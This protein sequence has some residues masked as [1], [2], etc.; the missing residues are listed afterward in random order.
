MKRMNKQGLIEKLA[1]KLEVTKKDAEK[2]IDGVFDSIIEALE[3]GEEKVDI[4]KVI[5]FE[6]KEQAARTA[7]NP[8]SGET[9]SVP[10]KN[11]VKVK[12]LKRLKEANV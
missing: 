7:R 3:S 10:A 12:L 9:I 6:V 5:R 4:T 2:Y 8:Q 11:V 1:G